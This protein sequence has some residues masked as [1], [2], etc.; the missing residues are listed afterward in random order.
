LEGFGGIKDEALPWPCTDVHRLRAFHQPR[1]QRE[2][3]RGAKRAAGPSL[4][5][6]ALL[7]H[8]PGKSPLEPPLQRCRS[9][10]R[11]S[12]PYPKSRRRK[13]RSATACPVRAAT[14]TTRRHARLSHLQIAGT[15]LAQS[16]R[17][18]FRGGAACRGRSQHWRIDRRRT[19]APAE[20]A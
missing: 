11:R 20:G 3:K 6:K 7:P 13:S 4:L 2:S 10:V 15:C 5:W 19:R 9:V 16:T 1:I 8:K 14:P 12:G 18:A 17:D